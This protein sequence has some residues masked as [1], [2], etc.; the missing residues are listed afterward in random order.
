MYGV[1]YL[2]YCD[3]PALSSAALLVEAE[4]A[5]MSDPGRIALVL[6][7]HFVNPTP[8]HFGVE[9]MENWGIVIPCF[10]LSHW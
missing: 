7:V 8:V 6:D 2:A 5:G 4:G 1:L 3:P 10:D 9:K